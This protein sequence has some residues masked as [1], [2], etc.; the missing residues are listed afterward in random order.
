VKIQEATQRVKNEM[1]SISKK[2]KIK[3]EELIQKI[4]SDISKEQKNI[5][6][7]QRN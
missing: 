6:K 7:N 2:D 3:L 1:E 4:N 5:N